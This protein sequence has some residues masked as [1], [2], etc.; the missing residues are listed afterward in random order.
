MNKKRFI[1]FAFVLVVA[2]VVSWNLTKSEALPT[3]NAEEFP[4][5]LAGMPRVELSVG[6]DAVKNISGLHGTDIEIVEGLVA[7]YSTAK[8]DRQMIVWVSESRNKQ[9]ATKLLTIMDNMMPNSSAFSNYQVKILNGRTYYYVTG[10]GMDNYYYQKGKRLYWVA[11]KDKDPETV[12]L[13]IV[14]RF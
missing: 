12:L 1:L 3:L 10:I 6:P 2:L 8:E 7:I 9:E 13:N 14:D 5:E 4:A 11:I